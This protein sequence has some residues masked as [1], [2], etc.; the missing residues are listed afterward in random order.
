[1][2]LRLH[3]W[4]GKASELNSRM[5]LR[6]CPAACLARRFVKFGGGV[7]AEQLAW[8]GRELA[9][10]EAAGERVVACCHLCF[11][12]DACAPACLLWNYDKVLQASGGRRA[13]GVGS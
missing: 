8:L 7:S 10:A 9:A 13:V 12:P 3:S 5:R 11:H 4:L 2:H 1:L 6:V